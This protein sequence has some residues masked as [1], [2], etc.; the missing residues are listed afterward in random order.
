M[1]QE[2]KYLDPIEETP[3]STPAVE[4]ATETAPAKPGPSSA[5]REPPGDAEGRPEGYVTRAERDRIQHDL[6][7]E[8]QRAAVAEDRFAKLVDRFYKD[9]E[10][11]TEATP[12]DFGPDPDV[13]PV[14]ALKWQ[15]EQFQQRAAAE[16][17]AA[18]QDQA[19]T[20][21]DQQWQEA[22]GAVTNYFNQVKAQRPELESLYQGVRASIERE[23]SAYVPPHQVQ[24]V[25]NQREAEIIQ[26]AYQNRVP[27]D[28]LIEHLAQSRGVTVKAPP[29][30][31]GEPVA[32]TP[33]RDPVTGQFVAEAE[34]AAKIATSQ[35]RNASL[36]AAP[37]APVKKMTPA[38]LAKMPEE[39]M[40]RYFEGVA[41]KP[42]SKNFHREMGFR[43]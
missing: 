5:E 3:A 22:L 30:T 9:N 8:R 1:A 23:I 24:A 32:E 25:A 41:R 18:Q 13:D 43:S 16:R 7:V 14:G 11:K 26:W 21:A 34:K 33:A 15:R 42:G 4:P 2:E 28:K 19:R 37:G 31:E 36:G 35:E 20:Q 6:Q 27:I 10:P 40:W 39:E 12:E 38:E 29:K 17:Q